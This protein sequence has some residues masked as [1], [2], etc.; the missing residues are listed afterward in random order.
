MSF[1]AIFDSLRHHLC[2]GTK[3]CTVVLLVCL[4]TAPLPTT[5]MTIKFH[6]FSLVLAF[7]LACPPTVIGQRRGEEFPGSVR[8][9]SGII[10][11][12]VCSY[13]DTFHPL[14]LPQRLQLRR[15]DQQFRSY[16]VH[17]SHSNSAV[18]SDI[19]VPTFN[20]RITQRRLRAQPMTYEIG[21]H[22]RTNFDLAG[23]CQMDLSLGGGQTAEI[24]L[25]LT[26]IDF[27]QL[28]LRS[29][30][31]DWDFGIGIDSVSD[32]QLYAGKDAPGLL[33]LSAQFSDPLEKLNVVTLLMR[34]EKFA[35][36]QRLLSDIV[37]DHPELEQ[38]A[39]RLIDIWNDQVGRLA[40]AELERLQL[41]GRKQTARQR[42]RNWP[43]DQLSPSIR[44]SV[45]EVDQSVSDEIKRMSLLQQGLATV[46]GTI[47]DETLSKQAAQLHSAIL[48]ELDLNNLD[49][50]DVFELLQDD[51]SVP[52]ESKLAYAASALWLGADNAFD[53]FAEAYGLMQIRFLISDY[54]R[55]E[56]A[57]QALRDRYLEDIRTQEGFSTD[58]IAG[59]LK[60]L[61]VI[62]P[63]ALQADQMTVQGFEWSDAESGTGCVGFVPEEYASSH[64]YP[65][66]LAMPRAGGDVIEA[67]SYWKELA[68]KNG[69][70]LAV[71]E[72]RDS[73]QNYSASAAEHRSFLGILRQLKAGLS[74]DTNRIF[75]VG[76]GMGGSA[77]MDLATAFPDSFAAVASVA[78]L[79]RKHLNWTVHNAS[80]MPWYVVAGTKQPRYYNRFGSLLEKLFRPA[81][82]GCP[83]RYHDVI[84]A[85]YQDRGFEQFIDARSEIFQWLNYQLR[86][87]SPDKF[88]SKIIRSSDNASFWAQLDPAAS[89]R[90][91][92]EQGSDP[93]EPVAATVNVTGYRRGNLYRLTSLPAAAHI[94]IYSGLEDFDPDQPVRIT[95]VRSRTNSHDFR[96]NT[97]DILDHFRQHLDPSR[98][99]LMKIPVGR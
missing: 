97:K 7:S 87:S 16:F 94:L 26:E 36:A 13:T 98:I 29:L 59:L 84:F 53:N 68:I 79:G 27:Q 74:V 58:R 90:F 23:R 35:V 34:A 55:T 63:L 71:P 17:T 40:V 50:M 91:S 61:S 47:A 46:V 51:E 31:H 92:M 48:R 76:H 11:N 70:I 37:V 88:E 49:Q 57:E 5:L 67:I 15:I 81:W 56:D 33:K 14:L 77:A 22:R 80:Q 28:R 2:R 4:S 62:A 85:R 38:Q 32:A 10:L 42:S 25:G 65:L 44:V 18:A 64:K 19:V 54:C 41:T 75:I 21:L 43:E 86:A 1:K 66:L 82:K 39:D 78:G 8:L 96:A 6:I 95:S 73:N 30:S 69:F 9:N 12:G 99:C 83:Q 24:R 20:L 45:Q 93:L 3:I 72:I 52:P 60:T 89:L